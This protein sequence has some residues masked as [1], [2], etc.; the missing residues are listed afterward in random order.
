MNRPLL[1][2][3]AS[4]L[5]AFYVLSFAGFAAWVFFSFS[6][7]AWL[8]A[9]RGE[10]T[11]TRGFILFMD[12]L[13]PVHAAAAA[14][15]AS[16]AGSRRA[17]LVREETPVFGRLVSSTL[18][19]FLLLTAGYAVLSEWL[20]PRAVRR[21]ADMR[22]QTQLAR[23]Y[24]DQADKALAAKDAVTA[25]EALERYLVI[26]PGN[27]PVTDEVLRLT[28]AAAQQTAPGPAARTAPAIDPTDSAQSLFD[29]ARAAYARGDLFAAHSY[30]Q[31]A[32]T[33]DPRRTDALRL[34]SQAWE[35]LGAVATSMDDAARADLYRKKRDAYALLQA[36]PVAAYYRFS[37]LAT[38][39][40][41][42]VDIATYRAK[43]QEEMAATVFFLDE[44]RRLEPL[45]G[46]RDVLFY[47]RVDTGT[48]AVYIGKMVEL[49]D[50]TV[51]FFDI[52][53]IRYDADGSVQWH[54]AAPYGKRFADAVPEG[55]ATAS[56]A[57]GATGALHTVLLHAVD[58]NDARVQTV[59]AYL[60]GSRPAA[61]RNILLLSPSVEELRALSAQDDAAAAMGIGD[62]LRLRGNLGAYGASRPALTIEMATKM[63]MPFVFLIVSLFAV[64]LGWGFRARGALPR[65]G[66]IV[67][68]VVPVVLAVLTL[69]YVYGHRVIVAFAVLSLGLPAALIALAVLE[70][71]LLAG[72]LVALAGQTAR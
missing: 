7:N 4:T 26:D 10:L 48:E 47:N 43:A 6:A 28:R 27:G 20:Y 19:V 1:G 52:E 57:G 21:V 54:L 68:P 24:R 60:E 34:A 13:L 50:G 15:A 40:P 3:L 66:M 70:L 67:I 64:A 32:A 72:A 29:K 14:I 42:D 59:P 51:Y 8:P 12:W 46:T 63:V 37:A 61:E 69:L 33:L 62:I 39:Y 11:W 45:P 18:V 49:A 65:L 44:V 17:G 31:A 58:R 9:F 55:T 30:A 41:Q 56:P 71:A 38:E 16:L 22:Y 5:F 25:L 53:A 2:R 23:G 36:N 35:A